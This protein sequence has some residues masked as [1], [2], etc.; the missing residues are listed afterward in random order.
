MELF[1][2]ILYLA[3]GIAA[4]YYGA[5]FL[6]KGGVDIAK[7]LGIS[8]LVIGLTL[9]SFATSAPELAVS[10]S[11]ALANNP[12]IALGNIIGSNIANIG[13]ILGLCACIMPLNVN[14]QLLKSDAIIMIAATLIVSFF[15]FCFGGLSR[16]A[17][18]I[19][20]AI[21]I[22]YTVLNV[23]FSRKNAQ[24]EEKTPAKYPLYLAIIIIIASLAVL[25][26][27]AKLFLAGSIYF[28]KLLKLSDAVIGLT[29]VA[30]GTSLPEL[31][32]SVVATCKGEKDIAI[33]NA[34]GSNI[35]NIFAILGATTIVK[36][37]TNATLNIVDFSVMLIISVVL[38]IMMFSGRKINRAEG[39][40]LFLSFIAYTVYL[41][42]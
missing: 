10:I 26:A 29:V 17:G 16:I 39:A 23:Y 8:S 9:V 36:P 4:L 21:I 1:L 2:N 37:I 32:A 3:G 33:G 25:I 12:D 30:I 14:K 27:G 24:K 19:L 42:I 18:I 41:C 5:D 22:I 35:F 38:Y 28:A 7:R 31:A 15:Y 20:F 40:L 13:L 6:I 11:A 34:I